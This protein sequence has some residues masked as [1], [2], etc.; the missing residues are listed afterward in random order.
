MEEKKKINLG[1]EFKLFSS[2]SI[3]TV[4]DRLK[5][6]D[7]WFPATI[8]GT[9]HTDLLHNGIIEDPFYSDNEIKLEWIDYCDWEYRLSFKIEENLFDTLQFEGIDT[10][11]EIYLNDV[12]LGNC[13]NM[14]LDYK[15]SI[16]DKLQNGLNELRVI[17][18]SAKKI[19]KLLESKYGKL[20]VALASERVYLRKAQYSFGWDWGPS[21]PTAGI[22]KNVWLTK[23]IENKITDVLFSTNQI[24]NSCADLNLSYNI[25]GSLANISKVCISLECDDSKYEVELTE[26]ISSENHQVIKID[27]PKLWYPNGLGDPNLYSLKILL[28]GLTE[29]ELNVYE[30]QV[31]I[32]T[33]K[34]K[35]SEDGKNT[36]KFI[37]NGSSQFIKGVNWI[38]ADSFLPRIKSERYSSLL[39]LAKEANVNMVRVWGGGIYEDDSFYDE[40]DK[41]GLLIWQDFMFACAAYPQH[42]EFINNITEEFIFQIKRLR[43]HPSLAIWCGNNENEWGWYQ[44]ESTPTEQMP[45]YKI[46]KETIPNLLQKLDYSRP[47]WQSSPFG[48]DE[49]PNSF[50]SGNTHQWNIW[51]NWKDYDEVKDDDSLFVTEFG[52]Q[53]PANIDTLNKVIPVSDRE[54]QSK[55]FEFHNKQVEGPERILKFLGKHLP[56]DTKWEDYLYLTQLNQGLAL[57]TCIEHWRTNGKTNGAI[58]WQINDCWP[59]ASWSIIDSDIIPKLSYY[60]VKNIFS[61]QLIYFSNTGEEI[62]INL[63]NENHDNFNGSYEITFIDSLL[64]S[65]KDKIYD[66]VTLDAKTTIRVK[67]LSP[68]NFSEENTIMLARIYNNLG[69]LI[70]SNYYNS[71]PWKYC[72]LAKPNIT[73]ELLDKKNKKQIILKSDK[74]AYFVDIHAEG[75][76]FSKRGFSIL[77]DE[78]IEVDI[79]NQKIIEIKNSDIKIYSLNEY[80][81]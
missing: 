65:I 38:P 49:D 80:L 67:S 16:K 23:T 15:F 13:K 36:F 17:L 47:Y 28:V 25:E 22:W 6:S 4:P 62:E 54:I 21:F 7:A 74:P 76:L 45:G 68:S 46:F 11:A 9:V 72:K 77:P 5:Y 81:N 30:K 57:K 42:D 37:I 75:I 31:G 79:L 59:V 69:E 39:T 66:N 40:C 33:V 27:N 71:L 70:N 43:N 51:S 50:N 19:G 34:L 2:D 48:F 24:E 10:I 1:W 32:R 53:A 41:L 55:V 64:G 78:E 29:N 18:K 8:P 14:F 35:L 58:I 3:E 12:L 20:P 73:F 44:R 61:Q 63:Q 60:F 56:I 26:Q 52:F